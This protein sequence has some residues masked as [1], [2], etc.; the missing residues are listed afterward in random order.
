MD[1]L[2]GAENL[3]A[4]PITL[5]PAY[6]AFNFQQVNAGEFRQ[7]KAA[8]VLATTLEREYVDLP[9][10]YAFLTLDTGAITQGN[11]QPYLVHQGLRYQAGFGLFLGPRCVA[12]GTRQD[13][14]GDSKTHGKHQE[15][16]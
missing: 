2:D 16:Q 5:T 12:D 6:D 7:F 14:Q 10:I 13:F 9:A 1:G 15:G 8:R 11:I 3:R 4:F